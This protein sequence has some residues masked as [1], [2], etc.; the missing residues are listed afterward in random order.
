MS[1]LAARRADHVN[2]A[3][4]QRLREVGRW[5]PTPRSFANGGRLLARLYVRSVRRDQLYGGGPFEALTPP[6]DGRGAARHLKV[7]QAA[8]ESVG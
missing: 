1:H 6:S 5:S 7:R 2:V 8:G 3:K 4:A